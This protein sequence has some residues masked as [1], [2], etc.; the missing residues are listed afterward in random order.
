MDEDPAEREFSKSIVFDFFEQAAE[1]FN[2]MDD[3][4]PALS[5]TSTWR[6]ERA[7]SVV[8]GAIEEEGES[9]R[10]SGFPVLKADADGGVQSHGGRS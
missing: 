3:Q 9:Y 7:D 10:L 1:T 5:R 6:S 8:G 2:K 4:G